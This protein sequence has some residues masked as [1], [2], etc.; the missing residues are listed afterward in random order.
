MY[1]STSTLTTSRVDFD[2]MTPALSESFDSINKDRIEQLTTKKEEEEEKL[3]KQQ[4][5]LYNRYKNVHIS[6]QD[7][8]E[9]HKI[10]NEVKSIQDKE[11]IK[12]KIKEYDAK[13]IKLLYLIS[14]LNKEQRKTKLQEK[15]TIDG[16]ICKYGYCNSNEVFSHV[17][18]SQEAEN[19]QYIGLVFGKESKGNDIIKINNLINQNNSFK[20]AIN[21]LETEETKTLN[22]Q[23]S[24]YKNSIRELENKLENIQIRKSNLLKLN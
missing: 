6:T 17:K 13:Y 7:I 20:S 3:K 2:F 9:L 1:G 12:T 5:Q 8:K 15:I 22:E 24:Q 10:I 21:S 18:Q 14:K 16:K 19:E 4:R 23:I 11:K